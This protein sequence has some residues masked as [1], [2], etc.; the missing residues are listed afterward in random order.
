M[1]TS[2]SIA[3]SPEGLGC[4]VVNALEGIQ[5]QHFTAITHHQSQSP[6]VTV[7]ENVIK[8]ERRQVVN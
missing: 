3:L 4:F 7:K 6:Q 2:M 5:N 8:R 1:Q